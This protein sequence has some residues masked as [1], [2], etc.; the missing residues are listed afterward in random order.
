MATESPT[1][2]PHANPTTA[3][4]VMPSLLKSPFAMELNPAI[5]ISRPAT[6]NK[7]GAAKVG[8]KAFCEVNEAVIVAR[9][10]VKTDAINP[11]VRR[12]NTKTLGT[13]FGRYEAMAQFPPGFLY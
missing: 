1:P 2:F 10:G 5:P 12:P 9:R 4:S 11:Q 7:G 3:K 8:G 13:I 6:E